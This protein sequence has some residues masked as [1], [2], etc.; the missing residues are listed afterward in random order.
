M[1][2]ILFLLIIFTLFITST[3]ALTLPIDITADSAAL[4]NMDSNEIIYGKNPDKKEI[5][6]SL[7]KIMTVYTV[8]ENVDNLDQEIIITEKDIANLYGFTCAGLQV[9]DKVSYQ[10]LMYATIL[11]SAADAS[12]T[13]AYHTSGSLEK[14][15][16][17]MNEEAKK[18]GM[19]NSNFTD[20]FGGDDNNISTAREMAILLKNALKNKTFKKIFNTE[21][22][23][24]SNG[25]TVKNYTPVLARYHG[26]D[27]TLITGSKSGYTPE[28]GLLLASTATINDVNYI[29]IICKSELN[30]KLTTHILDSYKVYNYIKEHNYSNRIV[31]EKNQQLK[32]IKVLDGTT[33]EYVV[34]ADK[35][36]SLFLNDEEFKRVE[37]DY[38]IVDEINSEYKRGD[39]LGYVDII[40]DN[41]ILQT[42]NVYLQDDIFQYEKPSKILIVIMIIL[43]LLIILLLLINLIMFQKKR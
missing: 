36:V 27:P 42:Y 24:L 25:L 33:S 3:K 6:A 32:K 15:Y 41:E 21:N 10:D 34:T 20:S 31:L 40:V 16:K 26:L 35:T 4:I 43:I 23:V 9:G 5:L 37:Y 8:L 19:H 39:N 18:L 13:L 7:T 22:Y 1:K 38:H 29:L 2:K 14:F 11:L 30:E 28:A 17:L 12:Q